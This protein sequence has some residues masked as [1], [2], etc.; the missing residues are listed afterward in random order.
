[1]QIHTIII[2]LDH[3]SIGQNGACVFFSVFV[4]YF[5]A[6][7]QIIFKQKVLHSQPSKEFT[8]FISG[9]ILLLHEDIIN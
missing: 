5:F 6:N 2:N 7:E 4:K 9:Y 3:L 1:M 8:L